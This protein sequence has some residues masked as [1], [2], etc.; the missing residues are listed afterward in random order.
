MHEECVRRIEQDKKAFS[1]EELKQIYYTVKKE[2]QN[3]PFISM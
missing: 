3:S 2:I 1:E